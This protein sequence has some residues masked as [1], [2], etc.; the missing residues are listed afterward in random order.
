MPSQSI[1]SSE[2][3]PATPLR[4]TLQHTATNK[5]L[6]PTMQAFVSFAIVLA[7]ESF[8]ADGADERSF[9]RVCAQM[10]AEIVSSCETF[11][12][13]SALKC[14]GVFLDAVV[15]SASA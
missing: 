12:A 1:S 10:R 13:E 9:I 2:S 11:G 6:L 5:F 14:G 8:L 4:R 15:I 3:S 7:R